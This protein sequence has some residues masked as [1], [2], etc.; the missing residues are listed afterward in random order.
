MY[1]KVLK[2]YDR[3]TRV[4]RQFLWDIGRELL[5]NP[6]TPTSPLQVAK[7]LEQLQAAA[8]ETI[9]I[10]NPGSVGLKELSGYK[11]RVKLYGEKNSSFTTPEPEVDFR[12]STATAHRLMA[13]TYAGRLQKFGTAS[14]AAGS[15]A[16]P[17]ANMID[18]T[19]TGE[20]K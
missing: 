8:T 13:T 3:N 16:V 5:N 14:R 12:D 9:N 18:S 6:E 11:G 2:S 10:R 1:Q 4:T 15:V 20:T 17:L 7:Q 19:T